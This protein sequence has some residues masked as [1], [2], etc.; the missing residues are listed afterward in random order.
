MEIAKKV[1]EKVAEYKEVPAEEISAETTISELGMDSLDAMNLIFELEEEFDLAIPD[2]E[3][4]EMKTVGEIIKGVEQLIA[5]KQN[6]SAE[7]SAE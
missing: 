2:E 3:V 1:I 7:A 6:E 5:A 4:F